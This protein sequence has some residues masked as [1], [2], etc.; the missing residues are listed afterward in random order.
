MVRNEILRK[1]IHIL[2]S[3]LLLTPMLIG[4]ILDPSLIYAS[5]LAIGGW[6]YSIQ[7][8]GLPHWLKAGMQIP[9]P[10]GIDIVL[11]SFNKLV[12][13]VERDYER[14]AGWLGAL[15]G[16]VGVTSSYFLFG[17]L[18]FYGISALILTDG[19]SSI[20]GLSVGRTKVPLADGTIEGT[21]A[22]FLSYFLFLICSMG[23]L[24]R[25]F[26]I[27]LSSS[28]TELYGGEDN[29]AVPLATTL[30][31]SLLGAPPFIVQ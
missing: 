19:L 29:I 12:N 23:D 30:V 11:E 2:F 10:R 16:L 9:Q 28:V 21:L 15:S 5:I 22:G 25:A 13:L 3:T 1:I 31:A 6:I 17:N 14:R 4:S 26:L 18:A 8:R 20:V 27:A 7:V 24:H